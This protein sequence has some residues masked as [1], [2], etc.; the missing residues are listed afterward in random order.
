MKD[1]VK[2]N[3][4]KMRF[5]RGMKAKLIRKF[6]K[7][8]ITLTLSNIKR[9]AKWQARIRWYHTF[10]HDMCELTKEA[11]LNNQGAWNFAQ[12]R[13]SKCKRQNKNAEIPNDKLLKAFIKKLN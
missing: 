4:L 11:N 7:T 5:C 12:A 6:K 8:E 10:W 13:L 1:A 3:I 9:Y 2:L